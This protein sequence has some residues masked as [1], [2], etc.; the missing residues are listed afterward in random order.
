M[1]FW[2]FRNRI[3]I[4]QQNLKNPQNVPQRKRHAFGQSIVDQHCQRRIHQIQTIGHPG[5]DQSK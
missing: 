5:F 4:R 1:I 2:D 3:R